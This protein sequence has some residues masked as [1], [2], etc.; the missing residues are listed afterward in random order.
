MRPPEVKVGKRAFQVDE[1]AHAKAGVGL[2]M[3]FSAT[4]TNNIWLNYRYKE[5]DNYEMI[6]KK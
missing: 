3:R 4:K 2:S 6:M 1:V 5:G